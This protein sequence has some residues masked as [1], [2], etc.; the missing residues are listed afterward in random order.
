M[1]Q[2]EATPGRMIS[3]N[4]MPVPLEAGSIRSIPLVKNAMANSRPIPAYVP[5]RITTDSAKIIA[6]PPFPS[7]S[8]VDL[9]YSAVDLRRLI[10][11]KMHDQ[12][13][14]LF[15]INPLRVIR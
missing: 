9:N 8:A 7:H 12:L 11:C 13:R 6:P 4:P 5:R 2:S 14:Y 1:G 10:G 3:L 15:R